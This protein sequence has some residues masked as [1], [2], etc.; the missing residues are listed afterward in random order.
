MNA[1]IVFLNAS[2]LTNDGT[3]EMY[4]AGLSDVRCI[5]GTTCERLSAI[6]HSATAD[7]LTEL[8]GEK[9]A[10]NQI[11]YKQEERDVAIVFKLKAQ[12]P[13]GVILSREEIEAIGYEFKILQMLAP[14]DAEQLIRA[15]VARM[16]NNLS[17]EKK[18]IINEAID[19]VTRDYSYDNDKTVMPIEVGQIW[20]D[21]HRRLWH[22]TCIDAEEP[23]PIRGERV[24][25]GKTRE[26]RWM[27]NGGGYYGFRLKEYIRFTEKEAYLQK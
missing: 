18:A 1:R 2:I 26:C 6:E 4:T 11:E 22:I 8:L 21:E 5:L 9:I 10:V 20:H 27:R 16:Y 19:E 14:E 25:A 3:F 12:A 23:Y 13:E 7:I 15:R 17:R 24:G